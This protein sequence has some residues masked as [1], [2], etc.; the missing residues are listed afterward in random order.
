MLAYKP[1][2]VAVIKTLLEIAN[3]IGVSKQ[4]VY[5]RYCG[6]LNEYVKPHVRI[7][8]G[9]IYIM[10][11][12]ENIIKQ[13]FLRDGAYGG[14]CS[15]H[16]QD[17]LILMLQKELRAKNRQIAELASIIQV[18]AKCVDKRRKQQ[19]AKQKNRV[20]QP[21]TSIPVERLIKQK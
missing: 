5:K 14:A 4:A 16:V 21:K 19:S 3:E 7:V 6:K 15:N 2:E 12:G 10:E 8:G 20:I 9:T 1:R 13:D 18:Q 17:A 11:Q